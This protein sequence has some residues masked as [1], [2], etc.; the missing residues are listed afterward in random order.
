VV[1]MTS[2]PLTALTFR[3]YRSVSRWTITAV[4]LS[5]WSLQMRV[6]LARTVSPVLNW[7]METVLPLA[8]RTRVPAVNDWP[9][10]DAAAGFSSVRGLASP[11]GALA[12]GRRPRQGRAPQASPPRRSPTRTRRTPPSRPPH[13]RSPAR[14]VVSAAGR[15]S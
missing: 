10:Q 8:S 3:S 11:G 6:S 15:W 2:V 9:P 4:T 14:E 5:G 13:R 7:L 12:E 1:W